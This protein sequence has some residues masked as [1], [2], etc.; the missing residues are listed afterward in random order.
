[1]QSIVVIHLCGKIDEAVSK[2][3]I[4]TPPMAGQR[5]KEESIDFQTLRRGAVA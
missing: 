1:L 5:R 2:A 4:V 3:I